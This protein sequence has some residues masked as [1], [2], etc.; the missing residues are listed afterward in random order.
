MAQIQIWGQI[1]KWPLWPLRNF[2]DLSVKT[3]KIDQTWTLLIEIP[4]TKVMF[5]KL[6]LLTDGE[7]ININWKSQL[8]KSELRDIKLK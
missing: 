1:P 7:V 5:N 4:S 8:I 2:V 6:A 3:K